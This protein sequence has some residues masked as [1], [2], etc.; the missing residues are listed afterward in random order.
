MHRKALN[1]T[2]GPKM[3]CKFLPIFNEKSKKMVDLMER[4][5]GKNFDMHRVMFKAAADSVF[6]TSFDIDWSMQNTYGDNFRDAVL[7]IF[8][9]VQLRA[10]SVLLK[11]D[12]VYKLTK[13]YAM[14]SNDYPKIKRITQSLVETKKNCLAEKLIQNCD[15]LADAKEAHCSNYIQK[16]IQLE[17][18]KKFDNENTCDNVETLF[19]GSV[20]TS[21]ITITSI[22]LMLAIHQNYQDRVVEE[23]HSIFNNIDDPVTS[24][25]LPMMSFMELVIKESLRHF[26]IAPYLAREC[27]ADLPLNGGIVP[28]GAQIILNIFSSNRN[29][30]YW[31]ENAHEFYPERF[32]PE[33]SFNNHPYQFIP[34]SAGPRN[35]IGMRYA[36]ASLKIALAYLLRRYKFTTDLKMQDVR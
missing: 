31:G 25:H 8:E 2:L 11:W 12:P 30:K 9:R 27:T 3:I 33:N 35:C 36:W 28:K 6:S 1:P 22:T 14:D 29:P 4:D 10:H 7:A 34:F 26:P 13:H 20:D 15:E 16:C 18:E 24:D 21:A 5:I 23:L 17:L 19:L 32:L